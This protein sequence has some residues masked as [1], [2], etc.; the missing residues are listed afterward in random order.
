MGK[1]EGRNERR[2]ATR[3]EERNDGWME[4]SMGQRNRR[5]KR[6]NEIKIHETAG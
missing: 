2:R 4:G 1:K 3:K 6:T 5:R